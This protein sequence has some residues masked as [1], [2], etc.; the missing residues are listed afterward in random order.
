MRG[1]LQMTL[2]LYIALYEKETTF[3]SHLRWICNCKYRFNVPN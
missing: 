1:Q 3:S 2:L